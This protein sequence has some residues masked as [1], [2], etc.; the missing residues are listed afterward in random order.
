LLVGQPPPA[1]H[2]TSGDITPTST[3]AN[4]SV[5]TTV[6]SCSA[7]DMQASTV[8]ASGDAECFM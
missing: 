6:G 5:N 4:T 3:S 1:E 8:G 2:D 7:A